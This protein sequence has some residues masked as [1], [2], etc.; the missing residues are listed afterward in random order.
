VGSDAGIW[1]SLVAL[2]LVVASRRRPA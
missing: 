1:V 2:A